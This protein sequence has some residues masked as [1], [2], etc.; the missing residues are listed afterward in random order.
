MVPSD[1]NDDNIEFVVIVGDS[2]D[3][4]IVIVAVVVMAMLIYIGYLP[5]KRSV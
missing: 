4:D 5:V 1:G 2:E 3:N